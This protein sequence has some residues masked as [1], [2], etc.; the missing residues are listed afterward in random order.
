VIKP[1]QNPLPGFSR[2]INAARN[3]VAQSQREAQQFGST[4]VTAP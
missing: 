4:S 3:A 2:V 1:V